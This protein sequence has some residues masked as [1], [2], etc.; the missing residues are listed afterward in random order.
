MTL[1]H[2]PG[3]V[4]IHISFH[5]ILLYAKCLMIRQIDC[6]F[7]YL[8]MWGQ[9]FWVNFTICYILGSKNFFRT[10]LKTP[11]KLRRAGPYLPSSHHLLGCVD[12]FGAARAAVGTS[13]FGKFIGA[14]V[15]R[16]WL[17]FRARKT[18]TLYDDI[19]GHLCLSF[20]PLV[21]F[22]WVLDD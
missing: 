5:D 3:A 19:A 13:K 2:V 9:N 21:E 17:W 22:L 16:S 18:K 12:G 20:L 11:L 8:L 15:R 14:G 4:N 10:T 7:R 1:I 6:V